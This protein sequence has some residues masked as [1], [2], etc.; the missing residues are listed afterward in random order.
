[1]NKNEN[2]RNDAIRGGRLMLHEKVEFLV[3]RSEIL[4]GE[5]WSK[6]VWSFV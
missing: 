3:L 2:R 1:V 4:N 6:S 5:K